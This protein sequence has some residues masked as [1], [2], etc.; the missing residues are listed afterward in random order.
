LVPNRPRILGELIANRWKINCGI[1]ARQNIQNIAG[2]PGGIILA[3]S[4]DAS[5]A[6]QARIRRESCAGPQLAR[7][8][9][10]FI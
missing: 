5:P 4:G 3:D 8:R 7:A 2:H 1:F 9:R 10:N 6:I